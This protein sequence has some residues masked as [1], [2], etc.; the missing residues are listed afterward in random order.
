[1]DSTTRVM[2]VLGAI[3]V[4]LFAGVILLHSPVRTNVVN[5]NSSLIENV[6]FDSNIPNSS[7]KVIPSSPEIAVLETNLGTIEILLNREKAP[8]TVENF[9]NYVNSGFYNQTVFHRVIDGFMIQG[10]GFTSDG[11][12]KETRSPIVL[13]SDNGLKNTL[14]TIAMART[15][16]PDSATSQFFI[17]VVD[18]P[19]LDYAPGNPGYAVFGTVVS[20][21]DTVNRIKQAETSFKFGARDWPKEDII[22]TGAHMK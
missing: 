5:T 17:N 21:M 18:N 22:I 7:Q 3:V 20:G 13:E 11:V 12:P 4:L 16:N 8:I 15:M 9:V 6:S 1:M 14:G 2:Y 10:G 19:A